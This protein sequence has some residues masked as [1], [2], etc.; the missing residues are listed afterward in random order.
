M[1]NFKTQKMKN[2]IVFILSAIVLFGSCENN[3]NNE[4]TLPNGYSTYGGL[5]NSETHPGSKN[6]LVT[7]KNNG[8]DLDEK[9]RI[10]AI[11]THIGIMN[12]ED[13]SVS[14][15]NID[16]SAQGGDGGLIISQGGNASNIVS[17]FDH[18]SLLLK[19][20]T[21]GTINKYIFELKVYG[22]RMSPVIALEGLEVGKMISIPTI[23]GYESNPTG[24]INNIYS[25]RIFNQTDYIYFHEIRLLE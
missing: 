25:F 8:I 14:I 5:I 19:V 4:I 21:Q 10:S 13:G 1:L 24:I 9:S 20:E 2:I 15:N 17:I 3:F 7:R 16:I 23:R 6:V 11:V 22:N 12:V 18:G